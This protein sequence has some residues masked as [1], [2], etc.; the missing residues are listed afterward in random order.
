M[1]DPLY[2]NDLRLPTALVSAIKSGIWQTPKNRDVWRSLFSDKE[3]VQ[4]M[5]YPLD[6][7]KREMS[8]LSEAGPAYL[9]QTDERF[10]PGDI[11]PGRAL[12]IAD[13]G[14]DRLIALDYRESETRPSVVALTSEEHSCWR[15]VAD[16]IES[17]MRAIHLIS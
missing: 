1:N 13:L 3:I 12:L 8:W 14:P 17:F 10:V 2:V 9:G 16:D 7:M 6:E 5:L 11:D 15:R 4:P